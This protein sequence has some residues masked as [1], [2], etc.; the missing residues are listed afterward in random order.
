MEEPELVSSEEAYAA[1]PQMILKFYEHE[2]GWG[3]DED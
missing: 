1:V 3:D 2:M